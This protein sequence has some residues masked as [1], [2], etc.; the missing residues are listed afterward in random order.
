MKCDV[1]W[2]GTGQG[3]GSHEQTNVDNIYAIGDV[4]EGRPELTPVAIQV[5]RL[6]VCRCCRD[7][8]SAA[9]ATPSCAQGKEHVVSRASSW[10]A[11]KSEIFGSWIGQV[12]GLQCGDGI[13]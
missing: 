3:V 4:L 10:R 1:A 8:A 13:E 2:Q 7:A 5:R 6:S 9:S 12:R 11:T